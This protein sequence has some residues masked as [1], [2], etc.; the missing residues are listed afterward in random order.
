MSC[1]PWQKPQHPKARAIL[2]FSL[3][4]LLAPLFSGCDSSREVVLDGLIMGTS[5]QVKIRHVPKEASDQVL[6]L[7]VS[8]ELNRMNRIFSTYLKS[9]E[10]SQLNQL[11]AGKSVQMSADLCA[12][13]N[14]SKSIHQ[15]TLGAFNPTIAPLVNVWG[16]GPNEVNAN[17]S[18]QV[19]DEAL[20][21]TGM[22]RVSIDNCKLT[23]LKPVSYDFSAIAKG[24]AVDKVSELLK[25]MDLPYHLVEIG[26]E[27]RSSVPNE[28]D[29]P[30]RPWFIGIEKPET[31]G[32]RKAVAAINLTDQAVATSGDYRNY[33]EVDGKR[34]SHMIDPNTGYPVSHALASVTVISNNCATADALATGLNV[35]GPQKAMQVA[36]QNKLAIY[37]VTHR[38]GRFELDFSTEFNAFLSK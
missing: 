28:D 17:P 33:K 8:A 25:G 31:S 7:A 30:V 35:L 29:K 6:N 5:Y 26:G 24:Y 2:W 10:L 9:S 3:F 4:A 15:M 11:E 38:E 36:E 18:Q 14:L 22:D 13:F 1:M 27:I 16:F 37:T 19:I 21:Q 23:K 34:Y 20:S 12:V 32:V